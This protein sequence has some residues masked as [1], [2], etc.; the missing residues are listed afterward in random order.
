V[1]A[2]ETVSDEDIAAYEAALK[3]GLT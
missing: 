3:E 1:A 2:T